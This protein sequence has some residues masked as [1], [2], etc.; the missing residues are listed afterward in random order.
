M[1]KN[2]LKQRKKLSVMDGPTDRQS[3]QVVE[4]R[5]RD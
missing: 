5:A 4:S 3:E 1:T 2:Y